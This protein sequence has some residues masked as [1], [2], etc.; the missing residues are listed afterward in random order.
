MNLLTKDKES[1]LRSIYGDQNRYLQI[2]LNFTSN[3]VKFTPSNGKIRID[4]EIVDEKLE[5]QEVEILRNETITIITKSSRK[6]D[7]E[8]GMN[9]SDE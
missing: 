8:H 6:S 4:V 7:S 2:L 5:E 9:S 1:V 3:A